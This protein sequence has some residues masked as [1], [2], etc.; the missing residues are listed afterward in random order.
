MQMFMLS[1]DEMGSVI[2]LGAKESCEFFHD[3]F[4][5]GR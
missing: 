2:S 4:K 3:P 1:V 5:G